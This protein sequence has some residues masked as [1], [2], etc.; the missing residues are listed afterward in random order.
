M[1]PNFAHFCLSLIADRPSYELSQHGWRGRNKCL[2]YLG[3]CR[4]FLVRSFDL[5]G[6]GRSDDYIPGLRGHARS[7][8]DHIT[9]IG[10]QLDS[11]RSAA[12]GKEAQFVLDPNLS[13]T[14]S[15]S[16]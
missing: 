7:F 3:D 14:S 8:D 16:K 1:L 5:Q 6:H 11:L 13:I 10:Q 2:L 9:D 15:H 4:R 12:P